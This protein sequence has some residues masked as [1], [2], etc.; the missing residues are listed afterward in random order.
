MHLTLD[1]DRSQTCRCRGSLDL[2]FEP[3]HLGV[4]GSRVL[5]L[6]QIHDLARRGGLGVCFWPVSNVGCTLRVY[7]S[8]CM[9]AC[10]RGPL[11]ARH[12]PSPL[13]VRS[14]GSLVG[15]SPLLACSST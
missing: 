3:L 8:I 14:L 5:V 7:I 1:L 11:P 9:W 12:T 6:L 2:H 15:V 4:S 13:R 10:I